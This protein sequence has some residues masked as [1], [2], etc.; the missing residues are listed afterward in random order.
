MSNHLDPDRSIARWLTSEA[1][2]RAPERLLEAARAQLS[3]TTQR[4]PLWAV[5]RIQAMNSYAKLAMAAAA[6][7]VVAVVGINLGSGMNTVSSEASPTSSPSASPTAASSVAPS[8][9]A[10]PQ[11]PVRGDLGRR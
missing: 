4:R 2:D 3:S 6:V 8:A 5:R 10:A 1:P 9:P 11:P 7:A